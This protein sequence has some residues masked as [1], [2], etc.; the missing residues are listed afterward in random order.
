MTNM[1]F[2]HHIQ[3]YAN[4][5]RK[6]REMVE[7][8][9]GLKYHLIP[10]DISLDALKAS[11]EAKVK[12]LNDKYPK[13]KPIRFRQHDTSFRVDVDEYNVVFILTYAKVH[14]YFVFGEDSLSIEKLPTISG[15]CKVCGC[16]E[17]NPCFN[18]EHDTCWWVDED[19]TL[20][21][22]CVDPEIK[23]D[24]KTVHCINS[25]GGMK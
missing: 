24:P 2:I 14:G 23:D 8:I 25:K 17:D 18:P 1:Y 22:H 19:H 5:N 10:D 20:C 13:S 6:G 16:T 21:S 3:T 12:E 4:V 11:V 15:V 9:S 7:F